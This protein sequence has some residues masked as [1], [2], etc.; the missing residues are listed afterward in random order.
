MIAMN[1]THSTSFIVMP[2]QTNYHYPMIFG[3]A[4]M[5]E[6]D[7]AAAACVS[8]LLHDSECDGAVTFKVLEGIF[9]APAQCGDLLFLNAKVIELR[10]KSVTVMVEA[11]RERRAKKGQDKIAKFVFVFVT[12]VGDA[13]CPHGLR[14]PE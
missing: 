5:A 11:Y 4:F 14:M 9:Y 6:L 13:F 10:H 8:R 1:L 12:K 2:T 7:K 3:G